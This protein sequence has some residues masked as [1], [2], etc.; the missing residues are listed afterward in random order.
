MQWDFIL[1]GGS[2][3]GSALQAVSVGFSLASLYLV[4]IFNQCSWCTTISSRRP[5]F[6]DKFWRRS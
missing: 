6:R 1:L 2:Y 3:F 4:L 5:V